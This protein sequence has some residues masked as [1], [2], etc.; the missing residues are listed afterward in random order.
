MP[1]LLAA[2]HAKGIL[3]D[4][5]TVPGEAGGHQKKYMGVARWERMINKSSTCEKKSS[6]A[7]D[8][9]FKLSSSSSRYHSCSLVGSVI[10]NYFVLSFGNVKFKPLLDVETF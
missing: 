1:P 3:T 6:P 9:W 4:D 8:S 7:Q 2:L 10:K 5:L